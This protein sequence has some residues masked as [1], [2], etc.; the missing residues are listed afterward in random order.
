VDAD[1]LSFREQI[2]L[3]SLEGHLQIMDGRTEEGVAVLQRLAQQA[4]EAHNVELAADIWRRLA[5]L[6]A[7]LRDD[8]A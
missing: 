7:N 3:R 4:H 6:L 8:T 5:E 1:R 2:R